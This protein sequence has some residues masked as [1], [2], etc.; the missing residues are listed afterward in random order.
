MSG[1][2]CISPVRIVLYAFK[3]GIMYYPMFDYDT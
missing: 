1:V 2:L 3:L